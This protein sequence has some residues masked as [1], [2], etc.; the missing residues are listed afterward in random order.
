[1]SSKFTESTVEEA[2]LEWTDGLACAVLHGPEIAP[3]ERAAE[4]ESFGDVVL[5]G[6][7]QDAIGRINP[8][9]PSEARDE[10]FRRVLR[11]D[12]T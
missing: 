7:L 4:R 2:V 1:M 11:T 9:I 3:G 12:F 8:Q 10:A 6:R 5:V